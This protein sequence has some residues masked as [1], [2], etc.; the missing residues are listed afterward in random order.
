M[1]SGAPEGALESSSPQRRNLRAVRKEQTREMLLGAAREVF[2]ERGYAD[3]TVDDIT[4]LTG[5]SRGTFYVHFPSKAAVMAELIVR[6]REETTARLRRD[7]PQ[8]LDSLE[9]LETWLH[10]FVEHY[11][12][13]RD[14]LRAWAQAEAIELGL[15]HLLFHNFQE[16]L[17]RYHLAVS[18]SGRHDQRSETERSTDVVLFTAMAERTLQLWLLDGFDLDEDHVIQR[19]ARD[20]YLAIYGILPDGR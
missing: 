13:Q 6:Q 20:W 8:H 10:R 17:E 12:E 15:R 11:R 3:A 1:S 19:L 18:H 5:A 16:R 9:G 4:A 2:E 14:F 7:V